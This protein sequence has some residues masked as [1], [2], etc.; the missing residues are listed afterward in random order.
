[1]SEPV[2]A[3]MVH[4][5]LR[6]ATGMATG[7]RPAGRLLAAAAALLARPR[8]SLGAVRDD[9]ATML[10]LAKAGVSGRYLRLPKRTLVAALAA[11]IYFV[12]PVDLIPDV[13]PVLGFA[14]DAAVVGWVLGRIRQDLDAFRAWEMGES[15]VIDVEAT[16]TEP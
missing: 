6:R 11:L 14:D 16:L 4:A 8:S 9:A 15:D 3:R 10:R 1:M 7:R 5:A 13:V 2:V 12:N